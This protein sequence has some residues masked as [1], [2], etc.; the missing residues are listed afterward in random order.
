MRE[1]DTVMPE[2]YRPLPHEYTEASPVHPLPDEYNADYAP[3]P[4][5]PEK[6]RRPKKMLKY[7]LGTAAAGIVITASVGAPPD[8]DVA[9]HTQ[10]DLYDFVFPSTYTYT[11]E[12]GNEYRISYDNTKNEDYYDYI[13]GYLYTMCQTFPEERVEA[14]RQGQDTLRFRTTLTEEPFY[15]AGSSVIY[16]FV[17]VQSNGWI[18]STATPYISEEMALFRIPFVEAGWIQEEIV[19]GLPSLIASGNA[20][21]GDLLR[22]LRSFEGI[23]IIDSGENGWRVSGVL[24]LTD[25]ANCFGEQSF[26]NFF[27]SYQWAKDKSYSEIRRYLAENSTLDEPREHSSLRTCQFVLVSGSF[28]L[29]LPSFLKIETIEPQ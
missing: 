23:N 10:S 8:T 4:L 20:Q 9:I 26:E 15:A 24:F 21:D 16:P 22:Y 3:P 12:E 14:A 17:N 1:N 5:P 18:D 13:A 11:L 2:E 7:I 28:D 6:K 25:D 29:I 19:L 27:D